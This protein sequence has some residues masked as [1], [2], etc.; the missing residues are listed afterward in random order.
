[1]ERENAIERRG[2]LDGG[3]YT[4]REFRDYYVDGED[5]TG[6][7]AK[8]IAAEPGA[9]KLQDRDEHIPRTGQRRAPDGECYTWESFVDWYGDK[10]KLKWGVA[11]ECSGG[12]EELQDASQSAD[13]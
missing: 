3:T 2:G 5:E 9:G 13:L 1:M 8:W 7:V 10:A 12:D 11:G 6:W 4:V